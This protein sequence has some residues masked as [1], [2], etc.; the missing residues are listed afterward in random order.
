[1]GHLVRVE[2]VSDNVVLQA[3]DAI[4][5][6]PLASIPTVAEGIQ[7]VDVAVPGGDTRAG[8]FPGVI[9]PSA[10]NHVPVLADNPVVAFSP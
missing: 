10:A 2:M 8:N 5:Q 1:M 6:D 7:T 3:A 4:R 9:N